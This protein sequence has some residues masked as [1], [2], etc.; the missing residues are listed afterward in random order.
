MIRTQGIVGVKA[1]RLVFLGV[2]ANSM[3]AGVSGVEWSEGK[4]K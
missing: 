1:L 2:M 4:G 3:E